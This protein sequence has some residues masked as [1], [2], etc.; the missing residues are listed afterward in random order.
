MPL[1]QFIGIIAL[2][3]TIGLTALSGIVWLKTRRSFWG[4]VTLILPA[5]Y[6]ALLVVVTSLST[7]EVLPVGTPQHF[8]GLYLDCHLSATVTGVE[9]G[10]G[11][12]RVTIR[13][14]N[15]ARRVSLAPV[16]LRV[17]LLQ[18]DSAAVRLV[19]A[20]EDIEG[21]IVAGGAREIVVTVPAP[22]NGETPTLRVTEG[23]GVDRVIEGI[24]LGDD[25]ALGKNRVELGL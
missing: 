12:W 15:D 6:L 24:L 21:Q 22:R 9:R 5:L 11:E 2:L 13:I 23:F 20:G 10:A 7:R 19:P 8:C 3:G 17:E 1:I 14:G 4:R 16:G 18:Q 25:D